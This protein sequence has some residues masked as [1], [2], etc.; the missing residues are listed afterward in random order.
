MNAGQSLQSAG[1]GPAE[2][3][4][5][6]AFLRDGFAGLATAN[7]FLFVLISASLT[8]LSH[9]NFLLFH[10]A[11]EGV[12]IV[13]GVMMCVV[14][15][16]SARFAANAGMV[17]AANG[18]FWVAMTDFLHV[19]A[20]KGMG[21]FQTEGANE[22]TQLWLM[23][24]FLQALAL[25]L[26]PLAV[27]NRISRIQSFLMFGVLASGLWAL[28]F[29]GLFPDAYREGS[30]LTVFK[31]CS[32]YAVIV[33]LAVALALVWRRRAAVG[34]AVAPGLAMAIILSMA[35]EGMF[36]LYINVYGLSNIIGHLLK[37]AALWVLFH[38]VVK[39]GLLMPYHA[40]L[41]EVAHRAQVEQD[42]RRSNA[43]LEAFAHVASHDLREPLRNISGYV[44][45]LERR[46]TARLDDDARQFIG[47]VRDGADRLDRLVSSLLNFSRAT[48][49]ESRL[50]PVVLRD[51]VQEVV[52]DYASLLT[53]TGATVTMPEDGP[54][55]LVDREM[56]G[57]V[58]QNMLS[59]AIK[60]AHP[61]RRLVVTVRWRQAGGRLAVEVADNGVGIPEADQR[62]VF[63]MFQRVERGPLSGGSGI[64]LAVCRKVIEH[65]GGQIAVSG[66]EGGGAVFSFDLPLAPF[67]QG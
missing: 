66:A 55:V 1:S 21:V 51:V 5:F 26:A 44:N 19:M 6:P 22:A 45:L 59:N 53:L 8:A 15:W 18:M 12:A 10:G 32:E 16:Y 42:L 49:Q 27:V 4:S 23:G 2:Q 47:F 61:E 67:S 40:L 20:Y 9:W 17:F 43:D 31:I 37:F 64:G 60:Y 28:S 58:F 63:G 13:V 46:Y 33:V 30:G 35:A 38:S 24:R 25:L 34:L 29:S 39:A 14:A 57:D 56:V 50:R 54:V 11:I 48:R 41:S 65:H 3:I 52:G 36:T 62:R 7:P